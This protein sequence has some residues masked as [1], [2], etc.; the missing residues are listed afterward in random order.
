VLVSVSNLG[1]RLS[2]EQTIGRIMRLPNAEEKADPAL[3]SAYIFAATKNFSQTS[4]LVIKGLQ[5]NGYEDIVPI[6]SGLSIAANEFKRKINDKKIIVPFINIKDG[7][8][9][10]KLDYVADLI[11]DVAVLKNQ[12]ATIDFKLVED[13][14]IVKIDFGREGELVR[15]AAGKL[16]LVYH[17]KDFTADDLLSWFRVKIQRGF[18]AIKEMNSYLKKVIDKLF[19]RHSLNALSAHRYQIKEAI[20]N[21]IDKIVDK[22]TEKKFRELAEKQFLTSYGQVFIFGDSINLLQVSQ[23]NFDKHLYEK[24]GK[25]N[26]EELDFAGKLNSL[27]NIYWWFRNPEIN[28][29]YLQGWKKQKFY[30]DFIAKTKDGNYIVLEYKGEH[31]IGSEGSDYKEAI[32]KVWEKISGKGYYFKWAEKN[33][34]DSIIGEILKL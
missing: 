16:G 34:I 12:D 22:L 27:E 18:I 26:K 4:D 32:G 20:E 1:A 15:D 29:F 21:K 23:D 17:F 25:M 5:E 14:R 8:N 31:L 7:E 3:N 33:N 2:V 28:G 13:N 9:L 10:R 6:T 19:A 11:G 24:A 30:P